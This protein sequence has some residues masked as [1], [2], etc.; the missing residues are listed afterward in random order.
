MVYFLFAK[1]LYGLTRLQVTLLDCVVFVGLDFIVI[2][3]ILVAIDSFASIG[4]FIPIGEC[5][6]L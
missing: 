5:I 1:G 6:L 2:D 3:C 4:R